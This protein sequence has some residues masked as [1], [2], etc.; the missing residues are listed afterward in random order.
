MKTLK[1][2]MVSYDRFCSMLAVLI[3]NYDNMPEVDKLTAYDALLDSAEET[4]TTIME[5]L[6]GIPIPDDFSDEID[7]ASKEIIIFGTELMI[8]KYFEDKKHKDGF[9]LKTKMKGCAVQMRS[10]KDM[11]G[12]IS[13]LTDEPRFLMV[14]FGDTE[15]VKIDIEELIIG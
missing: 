10:N 13:E 9:C 3:Y 11:L 2:S 15:I 8:N 7:D 12:Y 6:K 5:Q 4:D 1:S 14:D